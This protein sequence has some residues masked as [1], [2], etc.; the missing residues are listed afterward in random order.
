MPRLTAEQLQPFVS[1]ILQ[2]AG[3]PPADA[4]LTARLM[5][6]ANLSGHDTHGVRQTAR[7][8]GLLSEG[9]IQPGAEVEVVR[10]RGVTAVLDGHDCLGFVGATRAT[11]LAIEKARTHSLAAVGVRNLNHVGRVGAYPEMMAA[12]GLVGLITVNA[13]GRGIL[14]APFGG[15]Q[16]RIGTNPM[17]AGFPNPNGPDII[18]DFATSAVAANKIR[19]ADSRGLPTGEGWIMDNDGRPTNDPKAFLDGHAFMLPLGGNRGHKGYGLAVLVDI[20]SGVLA[21]AGTAAATEVRDLNNGTFVVCMDPEAFCERADYERQVGELVAH[22]QATP[23]M[24]GVERVLLPG[25][26]EARNR[27]QRKREGIE[28]EPPVWADMVACGE[29]YGVAAPQPA[30]A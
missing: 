30:A 26:Y 18:L 22:L 11:E 4:E 8:A 17:G 2:Q 27:E 7:Y 3:A 19:Q 13:Q 16:A 23:T 9:V 1:A 21:G 24:P 20:L 10:D 14:V 12:A 25:E 15:K 29:R 28:L 5:V 6:D